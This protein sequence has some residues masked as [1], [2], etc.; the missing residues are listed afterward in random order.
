MNNQQLIIRPQNCTAPEI[1]RLLTAYCFGRAEEIERQ[2]VEAHLLECECCWREVRRLEAAVRVLDT[3]SSLAES[4]TSSDIAKAF[5]ISGKL[6]WPLGG[7]R[8]HAVA[9]SAL[10]AGLFGVA[11]LG[12]VAYEFDRYGLKAVA[13]AVGFFVWMFLASLAGLTTDWRMTLQGSNK[14]LAA[15]MAILLLAA[16]TLYAGA[17]FFLPP[18]PITQ[19]NSLQAYPAQA[20]Y[21]KDIIYFLILKV[22]F[23]LPPFHFILRMQ[24][25]L[26]AGRHRMGLE[27][28]S[29]GRLSIA[30]RGIFFPRFWVLLVFFVVIVSLS[31]YLHT[32]LMDHLKPAPYMNLFSNLILTRLLLYYALAG[33]C[34]FWY[35][36]ALNELKREC[37]AAERVSFQGTDESRR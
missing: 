31:I 29:G 34:L 27:L 23:L 12:E 22:I 35:S 7:H 8:W 3:D 28:L 21:L 15:S 24:R 1:G 25:E 14:G 18:V 19:T 37:L 33:E 13:V 32:N 26:Q 2:S 4:L 30:P 11:L 36:H 16:F 10:Y 20:A 9:A 17:R 5:G 6:D